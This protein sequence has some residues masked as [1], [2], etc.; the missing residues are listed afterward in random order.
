METFTYT[1]IDDNELTVRIWNG[2]EITSA[3]VACNRESLTVV[4]RVEV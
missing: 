4:L 3:P 1:D 2:D